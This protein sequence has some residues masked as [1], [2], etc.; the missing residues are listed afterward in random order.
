MATN[1]Q[2]IRK[3]ERDIQMRMRHANVCLKCG[4][5]E[6]GDKEVD[7][8]HAHHC[9]LEE[10][11]AE[12]YWTAVSGN[13]RCFKMIIEEMAKADVLDCVSVPIGP[14]SN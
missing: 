7:G 6:T 8:L 12:D 9:L 14:D 1:E 5:V 4:R 10:P 11:D 2:R 3:F 13:P